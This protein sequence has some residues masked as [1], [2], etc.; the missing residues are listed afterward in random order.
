VPMYEAVVPGKRF[1]EEAG[2]VP[3]AGEE[4]KPGLR[5]VSEEE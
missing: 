5:V 1:S 4:G 3:E 2:A